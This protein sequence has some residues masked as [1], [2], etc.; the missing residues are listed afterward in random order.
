M[1]TKTYDLNQIEDLVLDLKAGHVV[2]IATDTVMGLAARADL[3]TSFDKLQQ[4]KGRPDNKPFPIMVANLEGLNK[5][6]ELD[7]QSL[8]LVNRWFPGA[9][10]FILNKKNFVKIVG[11]E[12]TLAVR[13]PDDK[14]LLD[15]VT[16]L[17]RPIF[18]TSANKSGEPTTM[19]AKE[20]LEVFN[21]E[22]KSILMR[23]AL[24]YKASTIVD[25]TKEDLILLRAGKISLDNIKESLE[26]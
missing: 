12:T 13:I 19:L 16:R 26:E 25:A 5:L 23:D 15:I 2:A 22:I 24:G 3:D 17:D 11:V 21:G 1:E 10:T 9:I 20:T 18:L 14:I 6:V 4:V 8:K 7:K